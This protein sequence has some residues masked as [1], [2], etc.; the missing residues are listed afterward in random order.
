MFREVKNVLLGFCGQVACPSALLSHV[1]HGLRT[2]WCLRRDQRDKLRQ[3]LEGREQPELG[4]LNHSCTPARSLS[5]VSGTVTSL[6]TNQS[7]HLSQESYRFLELTNFSEG[8]SSRTKSMRLF[9]TSRN[10]CCLL[11]RLDGYMLTR[12]LC[13]CMLSCSLLGSCHELFIILSC[14]AYIAEN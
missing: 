13:S 7:I 1:L 14:W 10:S 3:L 12:S 11:C 2:D 8:Y 4:T 6:S 9:N 5:Q